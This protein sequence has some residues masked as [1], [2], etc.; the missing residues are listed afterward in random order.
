MTFDEIKQTLAGENPNALF[1]DGLEAACIGIGRRC[2]QPALAVYDYDK[3]V[4]L[5][6]DDGM[7][8]ED[9]VEWMEFNVVGAWMGENTPIWFYCPTE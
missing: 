9:A 3:A 6:V 7:S 4:Q 1:A 8:H 2:G 5:F